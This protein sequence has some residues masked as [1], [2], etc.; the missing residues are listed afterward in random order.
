[1]SLDWKWLFIYPQQNVTREQG[2]TKR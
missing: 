2:W 1:V